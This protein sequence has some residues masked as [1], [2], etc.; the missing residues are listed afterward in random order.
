MKYWMIA[1]VVGVAL[2]LVPVKVRCGSP[3]AACAMPPAPG[4]TAPRYYYEYEPLGVMWLEW[5]TQSNL[6]FYYSSGIED[7]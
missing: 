1:A 4:G 5:L 2:L 6:P 3:S 7:G